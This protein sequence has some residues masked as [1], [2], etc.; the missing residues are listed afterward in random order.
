MVRLTLII[1]FSLFTIKAYS[2]GVVEQ[3]SHCDEMSKKIERNN[4]IIL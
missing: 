3:A 1:L 4:K 2:F